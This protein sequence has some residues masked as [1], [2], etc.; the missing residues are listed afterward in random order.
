MLNI[1]IRSSQGFVIG[2]EITERA[3]LIAFFFFIYFHNYENTSHLFS[4]TARLFV[5]HVIVW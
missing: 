2:L 1:Y 5:F 3:F 4:F